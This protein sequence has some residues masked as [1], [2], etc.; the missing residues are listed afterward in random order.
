[1]S[2][3]TPDAT[4]RHTQTPLVMDASGLPAPAELDGALFHDCLQPDDAPVRDSGELPAELLRP[5]VQTPQAVRAAGLEV[6]LDFVPTAPSRDRLDPE[7]RQRVEQQIAEEEARIQQRREDLRREQESLKS[8]Q[9]ALERQSAQALASLRE[10]LERE[11]EVAPLHETAQA[12]ARPGGM[13]EGVFPTPGETAGGFRMPEGGV[14]AADAPYGRPA[15]DLRIP[16]PQPLDVRDGFSDADLERFEALANL[17]AP[18]VDSIETWRR[19]SQPAAPSS[20][21]AP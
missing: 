18:L 21:E 4:L 2:D 3:K 19:V 17:L 12:V 10:E 11:A 16:A 6:H 14:P 15:V 9:E 8:Q 7:T 13:F 20:T 5:I 1:M